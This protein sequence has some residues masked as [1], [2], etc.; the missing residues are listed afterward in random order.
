MDED[1]LK[2]M[3][4]LVQ[5]TFASSAV[6]GVLVQALMDVLLE[7]GAISRPEIEKALR[8]AHEHIATNAPGNQK[9]SPLHLMMLNMLREAAEGQGVTL[10]ESK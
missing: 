1:D 9:G 7:S 6:S 8:A 5:A 2:A 10:E 3:N 4:G